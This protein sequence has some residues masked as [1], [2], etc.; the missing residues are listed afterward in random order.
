MSV[1]A[2]WAKGKQSTKI[3][4]FYCLTNLTM[5]F[6]QK[7]QIHGKY[8]R[9]KSWK[10]FEQPK[11]HTTFI[12]GENLPVFPLFSQT[13]LTSGANRSSAQERSATVNLKWEKEDLEARQ[14]S[15][16]YAGTDTVLKK[17]SLRGTLIAGQRATNTSVAQLMLSDNLGYC[18]KVHQ[19]CILFQ[20]P[21]E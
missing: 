3:I 8:L 14:W 20:K 19:C 15:N 12:L 9:T 10:I 1:W 5:I 17:H 4:W 6:I 2:K 18:L 16:H 7:F 11:S 13:V 21:K